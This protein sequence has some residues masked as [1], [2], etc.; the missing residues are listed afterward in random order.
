MKGRIVES[1]EADHDLRRLRAEIESA[2][3]CTGHLDRM[4][5]RI[6]FRPRPVGEGVEIEVRGQS[7]ETL[8]GVAPLQLLELVEGGPGDIEIWVMLVGAV[9]LDGAD[10]R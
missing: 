9:A 3:L 2:L 7:G 8:C 10:R 6:A 4:G 5:V 1:T